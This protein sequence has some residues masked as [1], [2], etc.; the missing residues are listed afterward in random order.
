MI[1]SICLYTG[2]QP[3][4][5]TTGGTGPDPDD[6]VTVMNGQAVCVDHAGLVGNGG[7]R[8]RMILIEVRSRG[9]ESLSALQDHNYRALRAG[10]TL[11]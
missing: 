7:D 10:E 8:H 1:C 11:R 5:G 6:P 4:D 9:F 3:T 2:R